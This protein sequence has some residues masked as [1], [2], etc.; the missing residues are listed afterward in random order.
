MTHVR[1]HQES[2]LVEKHAVNVSLQ[3]EYSLEN[4]WC[5]WRT[6]VYCLVV[7][8]K[9]SRHPQSIII[10]TNQE[11]MLVKRFGS[12][13]LVLDCSITFVKLVYFHHA[14][15]KPNASYDRHLVYCHSETSSGKELVE[16]W[17]SKQTLRLCGLEVYSLAS[18][19]RL[20]LHYTKASIPYTSFQGKLGNC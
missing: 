6:K 7:T 12:D 16:D 18:L 2:V 5:L 14:S 19:V 9:M 1:P 11:V 3:C 13:E 8:F 15:W 17:R 10:S 20:G 4:V